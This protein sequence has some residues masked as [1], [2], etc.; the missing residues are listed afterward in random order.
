MHAYADSFSAQLDRSQVNSG[1]SFKLILTLEGAN[2]QTA[3]DISPLTKD[4]DILATEQSQQIS[5][6][7]GQTSQQNTWV[8]SLSPKGTGNVSIPAIQLGNLQSQPLTIQVSPGNDPAA[9]NVVSK[10]LNSVFLDTRVDLHA[11][12]VKQA[13]NYTIK[14][15][16]GVALAEGQLTDPRVDNAIIKPLGHDLAYKTTING[17]LYGVLERH[18]IIVP[19]H[20]GSLTIYSP[21]FAAVISDGDLFYAS[22]ISNY[23]PIKRVNAPINLTV[24]ATPASI[25]NADW[26]PAKSLSLRENLSADPTNWQE[27]Q[28]ITRT[29]VLEATGVTAESLPTISQ[30]N[31]PG[32]NAYVSNPVRE[33]YAQ[34]NVIMSRQTQKIVFIP[35]Q[36]GNFQLP[37]I[38]VNWWNTSREQMVTASIPERN[39][40]V[41]AANVKAVSTTPT[42]SAKTPGSKNTFALLSQS[43][44]LPFSWV[45]M[46]GL[47]LLIILSSITML[48]F[49]RPR[50]QNKIVQPAKT[51]ANKPTTAPSFQMLKNACFAGEPLEVKKALLQFAA[52]YFGKAFFNLSQINAYFNNGELQN[53]FHELDQHLY[54]NVN[55]GWD[56]K[57]FWEIF[58]RVLKNK[59]MDLRGKKS[60]EL[61]TLYLN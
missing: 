57:K 50:Q 46:A 7:N 8:I 13:I 47:L 33:T 38:H 51:T 54:G 44:V 30:P 5:S 3:P 56:G 15:F 60:Q 43:I 25:G 19:E 1:D 12:Y 36:I 14:V 11:P 42:A 34:G 31:I 29:I 53:A 17:R 39:F 28:P 20:A 58:S 49:R 61:E 59:K 21:S 40:Q 26:L 52:D 16:Y 24:K 37:A 10:N 48:I 27:G 18:F 23:H 6:I 4:F 32:L 9:S 45:W 35:T 2:P 41:V 22:M 55:N